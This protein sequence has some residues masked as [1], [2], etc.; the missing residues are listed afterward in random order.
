MI[1]DDFDDN[2]YADSYQFA[3]YLHVKSKMQ[4]MSC[5]ELF[6]PSAAVFL[7]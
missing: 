1:D 2:D 3:S 4:V 6:I 7:R 5:H